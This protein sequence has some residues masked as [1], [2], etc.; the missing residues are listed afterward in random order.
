MGTTMKSCRRVNCINT[1]AV[2]TELASDEAH[3]SS[4]LIDD[5]NNRSQVNDRA[6]WL[7]Q[8]DDAPVL[9]NQYDKVRSQALHFVM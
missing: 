6:R 5:A 3:S 2:E 8:R 4:S 7:V 9:F 1:K